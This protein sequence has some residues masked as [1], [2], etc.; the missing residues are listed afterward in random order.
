MDDEGYSM[1]T[2]I[3]KYWDMLILAQRSLEVKNFLKVQPVYTNLSGY[4]P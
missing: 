3:R 1:D 4:L 2:S